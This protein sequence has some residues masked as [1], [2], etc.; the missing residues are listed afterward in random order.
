MASQ[1]AEGGPGSEATHPFNRWVPVP[2]R[3][4]GSPCGRTLG[5][6]EGAGHRHEGPPCVWRG[7]G[8]GAGA[9]P[10]PGTDRLSCRARSVTR[11]PLGDL[12]GEAEAALWLLLAT[13]RG[14]TLAS[15]RRFGVFHCVSWDSFTSFD[16]GKT[17]RSQIRRLPEREVS[18]LRGGDAPQL[19]GKRVLET[20]PSGLRA[21]GADGGSSPRQGRPLRDQRS[22]RS[23]PWPKSSEDSDTE[24]MCSG[25]RS[26]G[27]AVNGHQRNKAGNR[28]EKPLPRGAGR[29]PPLSGRRVCR[30]RD[31][32]GWGRSAVLSA[33]KPDGRDPE[34]SG[35]VR[36][37]AAW[38]TV[39][40]AGGG[41]GA[42]ARMGAPR[43]LSV[44]APLPATV[45]WV[46]THG[47]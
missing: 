8:T 36:G 2:L 45:L 31:P 4:G 33:R 9:G 1:V 34:A 41:G 37:S 3:V 44:P 25:G 13:S 47:A 38:Y 14:K 40:F 24:R 12:A 19:S 23:G 22:Q 42:H 27:G 7:E 32:A 29:Q 15:P 35:L 6:R 21:E 18:P 39:C 20:T 11:R 16:Y 46:A 28:G 43:L 5:P 26:P 17:G 30:E 10:S